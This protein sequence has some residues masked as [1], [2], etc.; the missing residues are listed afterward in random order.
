MHTLSTQGSRHLLGLAMESDRWASAWLTNHLEI[1]PG[2]PAPQ[3][4]ANGLHRRFLG[5]E[6]GGKPFHCIGFRLAIANLAGRIHPLQKATSKTL[7]RASNPIHF[8][9]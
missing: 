4:R 8:R 3:A 6:P 2:H 1:L 9:D 5:G 7:N